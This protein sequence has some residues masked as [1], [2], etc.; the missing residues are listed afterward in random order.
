MFKKK[1]IPKVEPKI[2]DLAFEIKKNT[3]LVGEKLGTS[4]KFVLSKF[5]FIKNIYGGIVSSVFGGKV[6]YKKD[7]TAI[8]EIDRDKAVSLYKEIGEV[9]LSGK[10]KE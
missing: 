1:I 3:F 6:E 8:L 10:N 9:L 4:E 7:W 2:G 5:D